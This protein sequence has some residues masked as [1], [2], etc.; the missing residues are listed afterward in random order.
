VV[1]NHS[2]TANN[3]SGFAM[4]GFST[5]ATAVDVELLAIHEAHTNGAE[6]AHLDV[7]IRNNG[8]ITKRL[9]LS[10]EGALSL[11]RYG[12]GVAKFNAVGE[13]TSDYISND[14]ISGVIT[15]DHIDGSVSADLQSVTSYTFAL[16]DGQSKGASK[17]I[18]FS[19]GSAVSATI[20]PNSSVAFPAGEVLCAVQLGAGKVTWVAGAGVTITSLSSNKAMA[21]QYS[22]ACARQTATDVWNLQGNLIP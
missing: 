2:N 11:S 6:T 10:K 16:A 17:V 22:G 3:F 21:G 12:L 14:N 8:V 9:G 19:S 4:A 1:G 20:P 18:D 13:I 15:K 5:A 7:N